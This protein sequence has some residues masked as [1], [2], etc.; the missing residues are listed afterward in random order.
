[1]SAMFKK[2]NLKTETEILVLNAPESFTPELE[3]LSGLIVQQ[4]AD[5]IQ[6]LSF[7]LSFV[8]SRQQISEL[9]Q[10][11]APKAQGD[12]L[13]WFAYPKASSK[14]YQC[15]FNRDNGWEPLTEAGFRPVRQVAIDQDWSALRFRRLEF[16]KGRK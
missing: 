12:A 6:T 15:D 13:L 1:M 10:Q 11:L 3:Q 7:A 16:S 14:K 9:T 5:Q 8:T 4:E 2:L